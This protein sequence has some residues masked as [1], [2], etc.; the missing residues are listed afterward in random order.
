M[1]DLGEFQKWINIWDGRNVE[2]K[3]R[4]MYERI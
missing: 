2:T 4:G 3:E 1:N